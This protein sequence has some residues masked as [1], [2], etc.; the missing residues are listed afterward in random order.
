M[1]YVD[2]NEENNCLIAL[3]Q[4]DLT[5]E[6]THM[7]IDPM[8]ILGIVVGLV[9]YPHHNQ[10]RATLRGGRELAHIA[11]F[12]PLFSSACKASLHDTVGFCCRGP[13]F[14]LISCLVTV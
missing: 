2:V 4:T 11:L 3:S 6:H 13:V 10:A 12:V 1:E 9:P 7:E 8:T 14:N 5:P